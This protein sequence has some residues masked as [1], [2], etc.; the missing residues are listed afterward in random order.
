MATKKSSSA[1]H[2]TVKKNKA[3]QPDIEP[4][5]ESSSIKKRIFKVSTFHH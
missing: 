5:R 2:K 4:K 1:S 3:V